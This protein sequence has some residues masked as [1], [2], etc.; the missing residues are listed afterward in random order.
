MATQAVPYVQGGKS[1]VSYR[2]SNRE[3]NRPPHLKE[4]HVAYTVV[5]KDLDSN[6]AIINFNNYISSNNED[7]RQPLHTE[8]NKLEEHLPDNKISM[9]EDYRNQGAKSALIVLSNQKNEHEGQHPP[10]PQEY[11]YSGTKSLSDDN[12]SK[13][14]RVLEG[15]VNTKLPNNN[16]QT[17]VIITHEGDEYLQPRVPV[18]ENKLSPSMSN[19]TGPINN[20]AHFKAS[21]KNTGNASSAFLGGASV[22]AVMSTSNNKEK[23]A[24]SSSNS[25][26]VIDAVESPVPKIIS[27]AGL[28]NPKLNE[29]AFP[30]PH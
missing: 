22:I 20:T 27:E 29:G 26:V 12:G 24:N 6:Y 13:E 4:S 8:G 28:H 7:D 18:Q 3:V 19:L 9:I 30:A 1:S 11:K 5:S 10:C 14:G 23:G 21:G 25:L 17:E 2:K 15:Y 16:N